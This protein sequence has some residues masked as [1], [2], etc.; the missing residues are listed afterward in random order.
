MKTTPQIAEAAKQ[1]IKI[2]NG[3]PRIAACGS[4]PPLVGQIAMHTE[5]ESWHNFRPL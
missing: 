4:A 5:A 2:V 3:A 1:Y